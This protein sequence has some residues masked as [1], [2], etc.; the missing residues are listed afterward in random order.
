MYKTKESSFYHELLRL[1]KKEKINLHEGNYAFTLGP[2]YETQAEIDE[3]I[4][5]K[6]ISFFYTQ[7][8]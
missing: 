7:T 2:S 5:L 6:G 3:I 8:E 4:K 1:A